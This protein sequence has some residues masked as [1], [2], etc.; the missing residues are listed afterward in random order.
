MS[1]QK[2]DKQDFSIQDE[3]SIKE[4]YP[5]YEKYWIKKQELKSQY[6]SKLFFNTTGAGNHKIPYSEEERMLHKEYLSKLANLIFEKD[7]DYQRFT[8]EM[9]S[10]FDKLQMERTAR[11]RTRKYEY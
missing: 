9:M 7:G 11:G 10:E 6:P 4:K 3:E 2:G 5:D 8:W 1:R